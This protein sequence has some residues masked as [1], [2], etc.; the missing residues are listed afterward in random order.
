MYLY[1]MT[2]QA[3][4]VKLAL[5]TREIGRKLAS[6]GRVFSTRSDAIES[7]AKKECEANLKSHLHLT[8]NPAYYRAVFVEA[9]VEGYFEGLVFLRDQMKFQLGPSAQP[10]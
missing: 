1:D 3:D 2:R 7:L 8:N 10:G 5:E 9:Y 6:E 4:W